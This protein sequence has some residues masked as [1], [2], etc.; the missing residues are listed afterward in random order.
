[1]SDQRSVL[2]TGGAG[3]IGSHLA[4]RLVAL[5]ARV[6]VV[7]N[8]STGDRANLAHLDGRIEF[9]VGDLRDPAVCGDAVAGVHVVFHVAALPSV[10]RSL[11]DPWGSHDANVNATVRLLQACQAEGVRRVVYSGS[12]SAYGD[13]PEL[14]KRESMEPLPRSPYAASKLASEHYVLAF[15]RAGLVEGVALRYFNVFGPRQSPNSP[16]AAVI[17]LFLRAALRGEPAVVFGDGRQTRDFTYVENVVEANLLAA[18]AP[19][20]RASGAVVNVGAGERTS[21]LELLELCR[22]VSGRPIAVEHRPPRAGDVRDSLASLERIGAVLGYRPRVRLDDGLRRTWEWFR[23]Q[24]G[25][26]PRDAV[27]EASGARSVA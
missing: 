25:E 3:F 24:H 12:S 10:P 27:V 23:R 9:L 6:R 7:D 8:L 15:A 4:D 21:L 19:A 22:R 11:A 2:V 20:E 13:T 16:Y 18:D 17:P 26:A 5:G 14:P 1:M